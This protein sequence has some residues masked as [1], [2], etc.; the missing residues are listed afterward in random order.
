MV[1]R[2]G[3]DLVVGTPFLRGKGAYLHQPDLAYGADSVRF[4]A[5]FLPDDGLDQGRIY[6][7][8]TGGVEDLGIEAGFCSPVPQND[9]GDEIDDQKQSDEIKQLLF[10]CE[11]FAVFAS[12]LGDGEK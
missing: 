1:V 9:A 8:L 2:E 7:I 11:V 6:V 10:L 4:E 12:H 3:R 5:A